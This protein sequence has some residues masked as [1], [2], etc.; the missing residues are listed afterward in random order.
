MVDKRKKIFFVAI[1]IIVLLTSILCKKSG[2]VKED[3]KTISIVDNRGEKIDIPRKVERVVCLSPEV[4]EIF[5]ELNSLDILIGVVNECD[6]PEDLEEISSVGSFSSPSYEKIISLEPDL[7]IATGLEQENFLKRLDE[8]D[9]PVV[10]LYAKN[11]SDVKKNILL[12]GKIVNKE[13]KALEIVGDFENIFDSIHNRLIQLPE[14]E[15]NPR[16]YIEIS[17]DPLMTVARG[18]FVHDVV[19]AVGGVNI[20]EDLSREYCR[21]DPELV[22]KRNPEFIVM[23][24]SAVDEETVKKRNGWNVIEAVKK[25]RIITDLNPDLLLR[26]TPRLSEGAKELYLAI[27]PDEDE[28]IFKED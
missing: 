7:I 9:V 21:I 25:D 3:I 16:V 8:F 28:S 6:Y 5:G 2:D 26:A 18:S 27:H 24:H 17:P 23:L 20:G 22:I 12:V 14:D 1:V 10:V 11:L 4:C 15:R 13:E 19:E